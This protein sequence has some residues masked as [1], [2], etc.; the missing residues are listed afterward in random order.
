M[1]PPFEK[2]NQQHG[3]YERFGYLTLI[4]DPQPKRIVEGWTVM[5]K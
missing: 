4:H 1:D 3:Q 2:S 5:P